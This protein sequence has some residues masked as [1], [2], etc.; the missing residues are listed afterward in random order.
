MYTFSCRVF[1]KPSNKPIKLK[2]HKVI[3]KAF[4]KR[5]ELNNGRL[6]ISF[7]STH[8]DPL[9]KARISELKKILCS[10]CYLNKFF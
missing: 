4:E 5:K 2:K 1:R 8:D 3:A 6:S 9:G 7:A 10:F